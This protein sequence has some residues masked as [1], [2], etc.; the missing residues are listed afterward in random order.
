MI[1]ETSTFTGCTETKV[2]HIPRNL[3]G[4]VWKI[5][6]TPWIQGA[7]STYTKRS[8]DPSSDSLIYAEVTSCI[9][10]VIHRINQITFGTVTGEFHILKRMRQY[11]IT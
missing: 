2:L 9:K 8:E 5:H 6:I 1:R 11:I 4:K 10:G 3:M 7:N